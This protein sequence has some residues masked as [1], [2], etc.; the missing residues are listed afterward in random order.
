MAH[1]MNGEQIPARFHRM[2]NIASNFAEH[3]NMRAYV[4]AIQPYVCDLGHSVK[5]EFK[6]SIGD[7]GREIEMVAIPPSF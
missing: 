3:A 2:S 5:A 6:T 4:D 1:H 7:R